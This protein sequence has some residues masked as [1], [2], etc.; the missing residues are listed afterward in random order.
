MRQPGTSDP[1]I[2]QE[3]ES[4]NFCVHKNVVLFWGIGPDHAVEHLN[5]RLKVSGR[6]VGITLNESARARFFLIAPEMAGLAEAVSNM[7]GISSSGKMTH[8]GLSEIY[9]QRQEKTIETL[10]ETINSCQNPFMYEGKYLINIV[11]KTAMPEEVEKV[12]LN[13][14]N[15]VDLTCK[16]CIEERIVRAEVNVWSPL[17]KLNLKTWKSAQKMVRNQLEDKKVELKEDRSSFARLLIVARSRPEITLQ[18]AIG[19]Y[20]FSSPPRSTFAL[21]GTLLPCTDKSNLMT[22]LESVPYADI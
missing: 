22:D 19:R 15:I 17:K 10:R 18:E 2:W 16:K 8:H 13:Y 7:A 3:C 6:I 4:G 12:M 11:T 14:D 5:M 20:E 21:N 1:D 9:M